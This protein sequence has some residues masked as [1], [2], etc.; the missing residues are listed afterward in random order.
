MKWI[1][2]LRVALLLVLGLLQTSCSNLPI[3]MQPG[4]AP[5]AVHDPS[6]A[7]YSDGRSAS[8][9]NA[10]MSGTPAAIQR[11]ELH[12]VASAQSVDRSESSGQPG[13]QGNGSSAIPV[14]TRFPAQALIPG[15]AATIVFG[16][17]AFV[18]G[19]FAG[20]RH[21]DSRH[22]N[23]PL[24]TTPGSLL[25][26]DR[27]LDALEQNR[28]QSLE[29]DDLKRD[30]N[31]LRTELAKLKRR[32]A[33]PTARSADL[34]S[35]ATQ[36]RPMQIPIQTMSPF[37]SQSLSQLEK[38]VLKSYN[39]G[40]NE[41]VQRFENGLRGSFELERV[42]L[43]FQ[44]AGLPGKGFE[45][46][47]HS[48]GHYYLAYSPRHRCGWVLPVPWRLYNHQIETEQLLRFYDFKELGSGR[49]QRIDE[50]CR[51][52]LIGTAGQSYAVS[53]K[54]VLAFEYAPSQTFSQR[55]NDGNSDDRGTVAKSASS[56]LGE[57][58]YASSTP[59]A[60]TVKGPAKI[61]EFEE[62][63]LGRDREQQDKPVTRDSAPDQSDVQNVSDAGG[64]AEESEEDKKPQ[65]ARALNAGIVAEDR[66]APDSP[67]VPKLLAHSTELATSAA[68]EGAQENIAGGEER[69]SGVLASDKSAQEE[70]P[71]GSSA[72]EAS[73]A[74]W[75]PGSTPVANEPVGQDGVGRDLDP[76]ED[77]IKVDNSVLP[78]F[79]DE[80]L[81][82]MNGDV[83]RRFNSAVDTGRCSLAE[84]L[85][86]FDT[87]RLYWCSLKGF[88]ADVFEFA[89]V[90]VDPCEL[91]P[92]DKDPFRFLC[93]R[94]V[95]DRDVRS[96]LLPLPWRE[97]SHP[98]SAEERRQLENIYEHRGTRPRTVILRPAIA[99]KYGSEASTY[100]VS[101]GFI[102]F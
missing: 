10:Q 27:L 32:L 67:E 14:E 50:L 71:R 45:L 11:H 97:Y 46:S 89:F 69:E 19:Y 29:N 26:R 54:G 73:S 68:T 51:V 70:C 101:R 44:D 62:V 47:P 77:G 31:L 38:Q 49:I 60:L 99:Y 61:A 42:S 15:V 83:A 16:A 12:P 96:F 86:A 24:S 81:D 65:A 3:P 75:G 1:D 82:P 28:R 55:P 41:P 84:I 66:R 2:I 13:S 17:F 22:S 87:F 85:K 98:A 91:T 92:K 20:R 76:I 94:S 4:S 93:A 40:V 64:Q 100:K 5:S 74:N 80:H 6:F 9:P 79:D 33:E 25:D 52:Q 57:N 90:E 18:C 37:G 53:E 34:I 63:L 7:Q 78:S 36:A 35:E 58:V 95:D 23:M 30:N 59:P 56:T 102:D 21:G 8:A 88:H 48:Q 43:D 39:A 72:Q